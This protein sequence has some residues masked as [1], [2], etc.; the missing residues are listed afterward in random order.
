MTKLEMKKIEYAFKHGE[1]IVFKWGRKVFVA[2][3]VFKHRKEATV[4]FREC[5]EIDRSCF[6]KNGDYWGD[7]VGKE[8]NFIFQDYYADNPNAIPYI[9]YKDELVREF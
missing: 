8:R 9:F 1:S 3:R 4:E 5:Y 6:D 2:E 7:T